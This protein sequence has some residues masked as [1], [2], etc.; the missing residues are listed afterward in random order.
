MEENMKQRV[1]HRIQALRAG[2]PLLCVRCWIRKLG[3]RLILPSQNVCFLNT[4]K[5]LCDPQGSSTASTQPRDISCGQPW[6]LVSFYLWGFLH[7]VSKS[8]CYE[9]INVPKVAWGLFLKSQLMIY[10]LTPWG[11][12]GSKN[13]C[14]WAFPHRVREHGWEQ[15]GVKPE[16]PGNTQQNQIQP[17]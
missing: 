6:W 10:R 2:C 13:S 11:L 17:P 15:W 7:S 8:I 16:P 9:E 3:D 14:S 5:H 4:A 12:P 1:Q